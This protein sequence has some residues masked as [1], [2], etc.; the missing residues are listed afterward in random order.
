V[1]SGGYYT[2][3]IDS[4]TPSPINIDNGGDQ[5]FWEFYNNIDLT[6]IGIGNSASVITGTSE[7]IAKYIRLHQN[8]T[9]TLGN[10]VTLDGIGVAT[11]YGNS[12]FIMKPGSKVT[13]HDGDYHGSGTVWV[14]SGTFIMDG[15]EISNNSG[16]GS[17]GY[18]GVLIGSDCT[19]VY[20]GGTIKDNYK[21]DEVSNLWVYWNATFVGTPD[22]NWGDRRVWDD[23]P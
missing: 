3:L 22:P 17:Y 19:F 14:Q 18:Y 9:L 21:Y 23:R 20:N 16:R 15:G 4:D 6:I 13:N 2:L 12:T 5:G 1:N 10:K 8:V 11:N 7:S